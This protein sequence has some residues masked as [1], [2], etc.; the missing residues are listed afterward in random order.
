MIFKENFICLRNVIWIYIYSGTQI[1]RPP[2]GRHSIG[3]VS[4]TGV[5]ASC[6]HS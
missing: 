1:T 2:A 4:G 6:L 3:R 5:V